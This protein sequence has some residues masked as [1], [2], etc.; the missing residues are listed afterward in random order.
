MMGGIKYE[1]TH[2]YFNLTLG[3]AM[4]WHLITFKNVKKFRHK[5]TTAT[6]QFQQ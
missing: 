2:N 1:K 6:G 3:P 4:K 5:F